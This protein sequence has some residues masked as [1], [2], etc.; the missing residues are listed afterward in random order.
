MVQDDWFDFRSGKM[1][2]GQWH[3]ADEAYLTAKVSSRPSDV[4][5]YEWLILKKLTSEMNVPESIRPAYSA[6]L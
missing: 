5:A 2:G 3:S 1:I 4:F 6:A